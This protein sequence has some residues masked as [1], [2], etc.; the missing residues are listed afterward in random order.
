MQ[1]NTKSTYFF[2]RKSEIAGNYLT[3]VLNNKK[4]KVIPGTLLKIL[5]ERAHLSRARSIDPSILQMHECNIISSMECFT[6]KYNVQ[7]Q[8]SVGCTNCK[9]QQQ[10]S[11]GKLKGNIAGNILDA[12]SQIVD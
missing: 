4:A 3:D 11:C 2:Q 1:L 6:R 12:S 9:K 5:I 8:P 7:K 10:P